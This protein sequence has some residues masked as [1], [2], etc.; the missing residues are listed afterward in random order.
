MPLFLT[1][2]VYAAAYHKKIEW[3]I[4]KGVAGYLY[5]R[6][7]DEW[8]S[9]ASIMA[10]SVVAKMVDEPAVFRKWPHFDNGKYHCHH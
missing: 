4:V 9:F 1:S 7:S 5:Q 10:A 3:V 6:K 8:M 2:G